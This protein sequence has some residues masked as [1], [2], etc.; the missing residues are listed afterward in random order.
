MTE[1]PVVTLLEFG[2]AEV[3]AVAHKSGISE[4]TNGSKLFFSYMAQQPLVSQGLLVVED[5]RSHLETR[6]SVG[7]LW[8]SDQPDAETS[9]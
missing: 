7:F 2:L 5:L 9:T 8:T 1:I 6:Q 4:I 3:H